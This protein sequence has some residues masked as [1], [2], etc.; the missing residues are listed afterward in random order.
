MIFNV[1]SVGVM[2][3]VPKTLFSILVNV[4]GLLDLFIMNALSIG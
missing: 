1:K 4:M 2:S 3:K